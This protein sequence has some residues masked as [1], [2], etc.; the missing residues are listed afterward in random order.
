[1]V[2]ER[3]CGADCRVCP[4]GSFSTV[5]VIPVLGSAVFHPDTGCIP[6]LWQQSPC[7]KRS[8]VNCVRVRLNRGR[9]HSAPPACR[10]PPVPPAGVAIGF[11]LWLAACFCTATHNGAHIC[12][13]VQDATRPAC[14]LP[15]LTPLAF[16]FQFIPSQ[17]LHLSR[18]LLS[19][20]S[21]KPS[22][23][24]LNRLPPFRLPFHSPHIPPSRPP[25]LP[26]SL[27]PSPLSPSSCSDAVFLAEVRP[28]FAVLK[29]VAANRS[30]RR[31]REEATR[32]AS[33]VRGML[34][35]GGRTWMGGEVD[36]GGRFL[37]PHLHL[38]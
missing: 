3:P 28:A 24:P 23:L 4:D 17:V 15:V 21:L 38:S 31:L 19:P 37:S 12:T 18:S 27:S 14:F 25:A 34:V 36:G 8:A 2:V 33:A 1:M 20:P 26:P 13:W 16:P 32:A 6:T 10:R 11:G 5:C 7:Q 35:G 9:H 29:A 30:R 22:H